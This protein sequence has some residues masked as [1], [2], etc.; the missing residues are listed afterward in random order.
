MQAG[1]LVPAPPAPAA[2]DRRRRQPLGAVRQPV[3]AGDGS[4][5]RQRSC[6]AGWASCS[7]G[8]GGGRWHAGT[9]QQRRGGGRQR[10]LASRCPAA[11]AGVGGV[12]RRPTAAGSSSPPAS[13]VTPAAA[14]GAQPKQIC[15]AGQQQSL[16]S[17]GRHAAASK[18]ARQLNAQ[19]RPVEADTC[20]VNYTCTI[21][22]APFSCKVYPSPYAVVTGPD[23]K[24]RWIICCRPR[25][26]LL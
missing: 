24:F 19:G 5:R 12:R 17:A 26:L 14:P 25:L 15:P 21:A 7:S 20:A 6:S 3:R 9:A 10:C 23:L 4:A 22:G 1:A 11:A 2:T 18:S 16:A 8:G 13:P